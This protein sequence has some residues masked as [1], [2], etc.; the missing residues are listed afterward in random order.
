MPA[1][2]WERFSRQSILPSCPSLE[3]RRWNFR[4]CSKNSRV[5][6][7]DSHHF[8]CFVN[9][10]GT[11]SEITVVKVTRATYIRF[12]RY[13]EQVGNNILTRLKPTLTE[14][15]SVRLSFWRIGR[16]HNSVKHHVNWSIE[17]IFTSYLN[18]Y[19]LNDWNR[20][21]YKANPS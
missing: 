13:H 17:K 21:A 7:G 5:T 14:S 10:T 18:D 15:P 1:S 12:Q 19:T 3:I 8:E 2:L 4:F 20:E 6:H 9:L 11:S 16:G